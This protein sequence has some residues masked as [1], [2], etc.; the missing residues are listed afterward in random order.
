[1]SLGTGA[2][3]HDVGKL[4]IDRDVLN[5]PGS[6]TPEEWQSMRDH[7]VS[8]A[9]MVTRVPGLDRSA[10]ICVLEHHMGFD[11][12]GYPEPPSPGRQ[13]LASRIVAVA[14]AYDAMTSRR[15]YS[16]ARAQ[17]EA[18]RLIV[19]SAGHGLDPALVRLFVTMLGVYP[20]RSVVGLDD[21]RI[22]V[23]VR[24]GE[25]DPLR[26]LVRVI[27]S[28]GGELV[29]PHLLDLGGPDTPGIAGHLDPAS[30]NVDVDSYL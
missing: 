26:P 7:P 22:A 8:G 19:E 21:G 17:E 27:A 28:P 16:E 23:V 1:M 29:E 3:L 11:G 13:H 5:K 24:P 6:L 20:P 25:T 15:S 9:R 30:L 2:L 10:V 14:D 18:M 4:T 12:A